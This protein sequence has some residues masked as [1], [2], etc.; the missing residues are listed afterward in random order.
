MR[1]CLGSAVGLDR[2]RDAGMRG[3][4]L[5]LAAIGLVATG[6]LVLLRPQG[7]GNVAWATPVSTESRMIE[8]AQSAMRGRM[9]PAGEVDF[10]AI[11]VFRF[12][13]DDERSVCGTVRPVAGGSE[14]PFVMRVLLPRGESVSGI[15]PRYQTV[16][17]QGPGLPQA[18]DQA[19]TR[20][21]RDGAAP[22][23]EAAASAAMPP[24][25][26]SGAA[27][28]P[29]P[30]TAGGGAPAETLVVQ[31]PA[32]LRSAPGGDVQRIATAGEALT[33]VGRAAGGWVQVESGGAQGWVHGSLLGTTP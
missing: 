33:V 16:L 17:E 19:R 14:I 32:R 18:G 12:G 5:G 2:D 6:A 26:F 21:C 23:F 1:Q 22:V 3:M 4:G 28:K 8:A 29:A 30:A 31:S 27:S 24:S 10:G 7:P 13:P 15:T 20:Y 11:E 9:R 25:A